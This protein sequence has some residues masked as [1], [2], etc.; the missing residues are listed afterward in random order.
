MREVGTD[1]AQLL[2]AISPEFRL[3]ATCAMWPPSN[4]RVEAIRVAA[5]HS[6]RHPA[7]IEL[8]QDDLLYCQRN[9]IERMFGHLKINRATRYG[10]LADSPLE[11]YISRVIGPNFPTC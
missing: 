2:V 8:H 1:C 9:R 10:Q 6:R 4:H 7:E 3:A 11:C 5:W